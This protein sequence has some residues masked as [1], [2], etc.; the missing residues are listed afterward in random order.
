M[1]SAVEE[2]L[3]PAAHLSSDA[4]GP[5]GRAA[6][7][8]RPTLPLTALSLERPPCGQHVEGPHTGKQANLNTGDTNNGSTAPSFAPVIAERPDAAALHIPPG[9]DSGFLQPYPLSFAPTFGSGHQGPSVLP[10]EYSFF[11]QHDPPQMA[12]PRSG[13]NQG[14]HVHGQNP[15]PMWDSAGQMFGLE[16]LGYYNESMSSLSS[17]SGSHVATSDYAQ[18]R[19]WAHSGPAGAIAAMG[20]GS[21]MPDFA[22]VDDACGMVWSNLPSE[23]R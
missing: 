10:Q 2:P 16:P 6:E 19:A 21:Q 23:F 15:F 9:L 8:S 11:P 5:I 12:H 3:H 22:L 17:I 18:R 20:A 7:D 14:V 1:M 4:Q 13:A